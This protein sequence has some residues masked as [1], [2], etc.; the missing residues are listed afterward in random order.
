MEEGKKAGVKK[1]AQG[2]NRQRYSS[3]DVAKH[4]GVSVAAV[5]RAFTP[6]ASISKK[7]KEKVLK[8][9]SELGYS[10]SILPRIL[11][12]NSSRLV[13]I[14][15]GGLYNPYYARLFEL[16]SRNLQECGYQPLVF[17]VNHNEYFDEVLP[18]IMRYR[19]DGIISALSLLSLEAANECAKL[20]VP[21]VTLNG[22]SQEGAM[23]SVRSDNLEGARQ[24]ADLMFRRGAARF[25][26]VSGNESVANTERGQ[27]YK[28]RL[29]E[30]GICDVQE[31]S[32]A[33]QMS[34]GRNA[35][36]KLLAGEVKPDAVF[37]ANDLMAVGFLETARHE[38]GLR[39]PED[40]MVAGF[41]DTM[42]TEWPSI[43]LT[44]VQPD[45]EAMAQR[46]IWFLTQYW[47]GD[48]MSLGATDVIPGKLVERNS[49]ARR[50]K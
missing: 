31:C 50:H 14:V 12:T 10:P 17:F 44:T 49:T 19:V 3:V 45:S 43:S 29:R 34:G 5:S 28:E 32:G 41:D 47:K 20:D 38:Y 37:C 24:I 13:A 11:V 36:R 9:A 2:R 30:L 46:C 16:F 23:S 21:I 4:A 25:A 26:Y 48:H 18:L 1:P 40:L 39:V 33:F 22:R 8:A 35:A 27:G 42:F 7:M 15:I 6:G